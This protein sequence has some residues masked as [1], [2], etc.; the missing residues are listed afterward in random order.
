VIVGKELKKVRLAA[1]LTQEKLAFECRLDRT[2]I[3]MLEN[4]K[5]VPTLGV[6][7]RICKATGVRPST[8]V[9]RIEK[10]G[11]KGK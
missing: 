9:G 5:K 4:G 10:A 11:W 2:Y 1:G 8:V 7:F 6:L 3:S